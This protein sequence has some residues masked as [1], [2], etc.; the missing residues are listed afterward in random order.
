MQRV[1]PTPLPP[2]YTHGGA[3]EAVGPPGW[4]RLAAAITSSPA[5]AACAGLSLTR[6]GSAGL[7]ALLAHTEPLGWRW[8]WGKG[9][10]CSSLRGQQP[11][12]STQT[13]CASALRTA[14][15]CCFP[16][17]RR[18]PSSGCCNHTVEIGILT[19]C[20]CRAGCLHRT[21]MFKAPQ[22]PRWAKTFQGAADSNFCRA[23]RAW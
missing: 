21:S 6:A 8:S 3:E 17:G 2:S 23:G 1:L 19:T 10:F 15:R 14:Q 16:S 20:S 9:C 7:A 22:P 5:E 11:P 12:C 18:E 4:Q 13:F